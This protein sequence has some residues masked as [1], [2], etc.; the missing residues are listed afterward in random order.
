MIMDETVINLV[1][2]SFSLDERK[3]VLDELA[4]LSLDDVMAKSENNLL[5]TLTAILQLSEGS[6]SQ[7]AHFVSC[8]K[9]DFRNVIYWASDQ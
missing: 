9:D 7:V 4:K 6:L 2:S 8:A 5:N 1:N 3:L